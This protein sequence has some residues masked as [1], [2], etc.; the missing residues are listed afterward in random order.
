MRKSIIRIISFLLIILIVILS[1]ITYIDA[2]QSADLYQLED[3]N[4]NKV[5]KLVENVMEK[6]DVPGISITIISGDETKFLNYGYADKESQIAVTDETLFELGSMSK[7]YTALAIFLLVEEGKLSLDDNVSDY[8][9]WFTAHYKGKYKRKRIDEDVDIKLR[10]LVYHTS[11]M[12]FE[13]LGYIP[14]GNGDNML[15]QTVRNIN[16]ISLDF[17]PNEKFQYATVNYDILGLIIQEITGLSYEEYMYKNILGP[18]GLEHTYLFQ[19]DAKETGLLAKGY[20][21][22]FFQSHPYEAPVYRGNAPAGYVI[23][24]AKDMERWIRFQMGNIRVGSILNTAME[25]THVGDYTVPSQDN[26]LYAGGWHVDLKEDLIEHGGENPNFSSMLTI[27]R[28]K[29][30]AVCVLSNMNS[31]AAGYICSEI[32]AM[33]ENTT[34]TKYTEHQYHMM[35]KVFS[36]ILIF[37]GLLFIIFIFLIVRALMEIIKGER[38]YT[39]L[40]EVRVAGE[41]LAFFMTFLLGVCVYYIPNVLF[42]RLPWRVVSVWGSSNV[43]LGCITAFIMFVVFM[44]YMLLTFNFS[45]ENE[46]NYLS[47]VVLSII[48]GAASALIIFSINESFNRNLQYTKELLFYFLCALIYLVYTKKLMEG[49]LIV[50]VNEIIYQKRTGLIT[51]I[52][53]SRY[54]AIETIGN[55]RIYS[56]LNNDIEQISRIPDMLVSFASNLLTLIFCLA[57]LYFKSKVAFVV[58]FFVIVLN[59]LIGYITGKKASKYWEKNRTI[60]DTYFKQL[61]DLVYGFKELKLN[62]LRKVDFLLDIKRYSRSSS[63]LKKTSSI[64]FLNYDI[65]NMLMYNVIFGVVVFFFPL[66]ISDINVN[67]LRENLFLVFYLIGPF[68]SVSGF[69]GGILEMKVHLKRVDQIRKELDDGQTEGLEGRIGLGIESSEQM[70]IKL[71]SVTYQYKSRNEGDADVENVFELGPLNFEFQKGKVV[72]ITGGNGSGKSTLGKLITGLY[73]PLNGSIQINGKEALPEELNEL[74]SAVYSDFH[75]FDKLYGIDVKSRKDEIDKLIEMMGLQN[76]ISYSQNGEIES[77]KLSTGQKKRLAFVVSCLDDKPMV[78]FDEWAAEQD[79][80][81]R[82]YFYEE[83]IPMLAALGKGVVVITHDDRYFNCAD[84]LLKLERGQTLS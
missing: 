8:L 17:Y 77:T 73:S 1:P 21:M 32:V 33:F 81:F 57:F 14:E 36:L 5:T 26:Q 47:L 58:S 22:K 83:L 65:Y 24:N 66:I 16:G 35:D 40:N 19:D 74:F 42:Y 51:K 64:K 52:S 41:P 29:Q 23:S 50:I 37:S 18:L 31:N 49:R 60:Q 78:L 6:S 3:L 48:N 80:V 15:E 11:G 44:I 76:V 71:N 75:L 55:E 59:G 20:K 62:V 34:S 70:C 79:P 56:A 12:P 7:A 46:K 72:F 10:D 43:V 13:S 2:K 54:Q 84:V 4:E 45:K 30:F 28:D 63:E 27:N 39:K 67:D 38:R 25:K 53:D 61:A 69:I 68:L 9:P 82:K